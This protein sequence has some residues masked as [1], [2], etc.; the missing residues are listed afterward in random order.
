MKRS[1]PQPPGLSCDLA[2]RGGVR[3]RLLHRTSGW[4]RTSPL[5]SATRHTRTRMQAHACTRC[6]GKLLHSQS[7]SL[8]DVRSGTSRLRFQNSCRSFQ[9]RVDERIIS[10]ATS[11][12]RDH[13]SRGALKPILLLGCFKCRDCRMA[14]KIQAKEH[15]TFSSPGLLLRSLVVAR[16]C[17]SSQPPVRL[18]LAYFADSLKSP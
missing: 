9:F 1:A 17:K 12:L 5:A 15:S 14:L 11:R 8:L 6:A 13:G 18:I 4:H 3:P 2:G 16:C 7:T 10:L